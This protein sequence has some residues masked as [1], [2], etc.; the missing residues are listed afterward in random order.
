M[1]AVLHIVGYQLL[2]TVTPAKRRRITTLLRRLAE[3]MHGVELVALGRNVSNSRFA[4]GWDFAAVLQLA[5]R[6]LLPAYL[7][8]PLHKKLSL[9]ASQDFYESCAVFD[10]PL[11]SGGFQ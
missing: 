5:D 6:K 2:D 11:V 10:I 1:A 3:E 7:E 4:A 8:H 9:E